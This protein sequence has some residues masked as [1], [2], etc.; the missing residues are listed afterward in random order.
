MKRR[1]FIAGFGRAA[2]W[3][4]AAQA[5][6]RSKI[7]RIGIID[8]TSQWNHF[9]SRLRE[10]GY[11]EGENIAFEYASGEGVPEQLAEA[12]AQLVRL[13]VDVIATY[14]TA[15]SYA[16]KNATSTIPIVMISIGDP[17][18]AGLVS[19]LAHPSGNVTGN[20]I[21]GPD[22]GAKRIQLLREAIPTVTRVAFL[23]NPNNASHDAYRQEIRAAAPALNIKL[24][25]VEVGSASEFDTAFAA[26]MSE[27]PDAFSISGD[28]FH[29]RHIGWIIEFMARNR[30]PAMY[31]LSENVRAGHVLRSQ[32]AGFV[33]ARRVLR[34]QDFGWHQAG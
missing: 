18:R 19:S 12:A 9:R 25:F 30:I 22:I 2:A 17:V 13:P 34:G 31:Q 20:T 10:L 3:P 33:P 6:Q 4:L 29:Q 11:L 32:S 5:Q 27:G 23:W 14:G 28:P 8:D 7:R 21:L 1:E 16:A 15:A 26:A 24:L